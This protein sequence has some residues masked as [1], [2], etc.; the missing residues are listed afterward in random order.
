MNPTQI[1]ILKAAEIEFATHGFNGATVRDITK[2][3]EA[4]IASINYHF[5]TKEVL[6]KEM[7]RYRI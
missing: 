2:R 4:N 1:K 7:V 3:A 5:G 6:F